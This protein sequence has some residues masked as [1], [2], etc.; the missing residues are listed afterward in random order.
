[1]FILGFLESVFLVGDGL[2][3]N[4]F[5]RGSWLAII[6]FLVLGALKKVVAMNIWF[7]LCSGVGY[8]REGLKPSS[9]LI[10]GGMNV[11]YLLGIVLSSLSNVDEIKQYLFINDLNAT[12]IDLPNLIFDAVFIGWGLLV[13]YNT[14][15][16]LRHG[17]SAVSKNNIIIN[18]FHSMSRVLCVS[19]LFMLLVVGVEWSLVFAEDQRFIQLEWLWHSFWRVNFLVVVLFLLHLFKPTGQIEALPVLAPSDSESMDVQ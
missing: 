9:L 10:L 11:A 19:F 2:Y 16:K 8:T 17:A 3:L 4:T 5:G 15:G 13:A 6:A 14:M 12:L 18:K 7:T 1:V